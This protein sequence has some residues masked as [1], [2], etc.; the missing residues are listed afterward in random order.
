MIYKIINAIN[1]Y[2]VTTL[3]GFFS[4]CYCAFFLSKRKHH[5]CKINTFSLIFFFHSWER[6][7]TTTTFNWTE[8][9]FSSTSIVIY[10]KLLCY[11][12]IN[13]SSLFNPFSYFD[14][15]WQ[16]RISNRTISILI[17]LILCFLLSL[18]KVIKI[19]TRKKKNTTN[20]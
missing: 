20:V 10:D 18:V 14:C 15:R 19:H 13:E 12:I 5:I 11:D 4:V 17:S 6:K 3:Y 1:R 9:L 16:F 8:K 2:N 7:K